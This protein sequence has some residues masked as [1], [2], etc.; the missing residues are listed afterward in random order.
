MITYTNL[1]IRKLQFLNIPKVSS[2]I[3]K[4]TTNN[5]E[6]SCIIICLKMSVGKINFCI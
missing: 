6:Y 3:L 1:C 4:T 5:E 2:F